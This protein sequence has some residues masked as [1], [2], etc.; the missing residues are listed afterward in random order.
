MSTLS[1]LAVLPAALAVTGFV[2]YRFL[3]AQKESSRITSQIVVK[4]RADMPERSSQL[5]NLP[6]RELSL[7][8]KRDHQLRQSVGEKNFELL[9]LVLQQEHKQSLVVYGICALLFVVGM[10]AFLYVQTRPQPLT[11]NGWHLESVDPQAKGLAVDLDDVRLSWKAT[12]PTEDVSVLLENIQ[13]GRRTDSLKVSSSTGSLVFQRNALAPLLAERQFK[14]QNR[15]RVVMRTSAGD[16][17]STEFP[18]HVG[19]HVLALPDPG[20][21]SLII[22]ALIDNRLVQDY[23][24]EGKAL[25]WRKKAPAEPQKWGGGGDHWQTKVLHRGF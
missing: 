24:F 1:F 11:I 18:L 16:V 6:A 2:I 4:L 15:V 12:G 19:M 23:A 20:E 13:T 8:L 9:Q 10:I 22:A 7:E 17:L 5:A 14:R 3:G 21:K 25:A